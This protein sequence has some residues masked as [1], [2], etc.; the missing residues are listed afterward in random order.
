METIQSVINLRPSHQTWK[1]YV[2]VGDI[3]VHGSINH[4][5]HKENSKMQSKPT[6][7]A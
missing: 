6:A 1:K 3:N 4:W 5:T 7:T 2:D